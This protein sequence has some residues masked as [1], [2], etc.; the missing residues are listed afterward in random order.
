MIVKVFEFNKNHKIEFTQE[1]LE[2]L[3]T[4]VYNSGY[5]DGRW[6]NHSWTWTSPYY[7]SNE[8]LNITT[9]GNNTPIDD[10]RITWTTTSANS[11]DPSHISLGV[12]SSPKTTTYCMNA[13]NR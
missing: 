1:E 10:N 7:T 13:A 12:G 8:Y 9:T 2:K 6:N 3:L 4:E 5:N 11:E